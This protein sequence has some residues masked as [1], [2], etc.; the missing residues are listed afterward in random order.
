MLCVCLVTQSCLTLYDPMDC[1]LSGSS[2]HGDSPG[3]NTGA[4][5]YLLLQGIFPTQESNPSL[6]HRRWILCHLLC[7]SQHITS[8]PHIVVSWLQNS[9]CSSKA[10]ILTGLYSNK[11]VKW[12]LAKEAFPKIQSSFQGAKSCQNSMKTSLAYHRPELGSHA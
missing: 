2:V 1:S 12:M 8:G 5:Y 11:D 7:Y 4:G 6:P 3:K 10:Y 9:F